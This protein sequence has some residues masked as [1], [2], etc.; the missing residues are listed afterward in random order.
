MI[1]LKGNQRTGSVNK[2]EYRKQ[3]AL[4]LDHWIEIERQSMSW[5]DYPIFGFYMT[6][7]LSIGFNYFNKNKSSE[8]YYVDSRS[9]KVSHVGLFIAAINMGGG[10]SI[11]QSGVAFIMDI[12][13]TDNK[14]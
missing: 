13:V 4:S 7:V 10:F 8:D 6:S 11:R 5:V 3:I 14:L 1:L 9:I 2:P 12:L